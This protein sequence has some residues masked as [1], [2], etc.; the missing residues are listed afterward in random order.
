MHSTALRDSAVECIGSR[1]MAV[2]ED[3]ESDGDWERRACNIVF[4]MLRPL[5]AQPWRKPPQGRIAAHAL[6]HCVGKTCSGRPH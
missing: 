1:D 2:E 3:M 6:H 5:R 4:R